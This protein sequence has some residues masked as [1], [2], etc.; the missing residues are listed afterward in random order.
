MGAWS[1]EVDSALT[2]RTLSSEFEI[3]ADRWAPALW[4]PTAEIIKQ[5]A[6]SDWKTVPDEVI[7]IPEEKVISEG[8]TAS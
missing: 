5:I 2:V 6:R 1:A 8:H 4:Q 3:A 7:R